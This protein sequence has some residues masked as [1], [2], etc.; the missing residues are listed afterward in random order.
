MSQ[1][2]GLGLY[3]IFYQNQGAKEYPFF[4]AYTARTSSGINKSWYKSKVFYGSESD[5]GDTTTDSDKAGLTLV[6]TGIDDGLLFPEITRRVKYVVKEGS[7]LTNANVPGYENEPVWL[8]SLQTSGA[9]T[10]SSESFNFRLLETGMFTSHNSFGKLSL[11]YNDIDF[12][13]SDPESAK[14]TV[15]DYSGV[16]DVQPHTVTNTY[17]LFEDFDKGD[18]LY[19][20]DKL[21]AGVDYTEA[22]GNAVPVNK[23][24][25]PTYLR[26]VDGETVYRV[27]SKPSITINE[28]RTSN[29][30]F[31]LKIDAG[32]Q[33]EEGITAFTVTLMK[34]SDHTN[35]DENSDSAEIV[36]SFQSTDGN[37]KSYTR[38]GIGA[39]A[40][41]GSDDNLAA[42]E[43]HVLDVTDVEGYSETT[44]TGAFVL[45][46]GDLTENDESFLTVPEDSGFASGNVI[47]FA[48]VSTVKGMDH[49][50]TVMI[51]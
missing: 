3:A 49:D 25:E 32:G 13:I 21:K 12:F 6:Y 17:S 24:S 27:A 1:A 40:T 9:A 44:S 19:F 10:S 26:L 4:N 18:L 34:E 50:Y 42:N 29:N 5:Q 37:V 45:E 47:V 38:D 20:A 7:N 51:D 35:E 14:V 8:L 16:V 39:D 15:L 48:S 2:S 33:H 46:L 31:S 36:L 28:T 30:N 43:I 11:R 23:E 41:S 22:I